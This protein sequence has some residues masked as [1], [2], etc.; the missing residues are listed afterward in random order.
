MPPVHQAPTGA[1]D[2]R[3][4]QIAAVLVRYGLSYLADVVG[5]ERLVRVAPGVAA[6]EPA[7]RHTPAENL[8]LALEELGP[9]FIKLGQLVSTRADLLSPDYRAELTKLLDTAPAVPS[10][11]ITD[12]VQRELHAPVDTSFAT[13]DAVPLACASVGQATPRRCTTGP[14]W[15]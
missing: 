12:I 15:S 13:F 10:D 3:E 5:L 7:D 6:R 11:V 14:T 2:H 9:T 8:R 1:R 4:R